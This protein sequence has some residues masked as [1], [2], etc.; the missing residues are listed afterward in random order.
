MRDVRERSPRGDV[1]ASL[2]FV[3]SVYS[4]LVGNSTVR[5]EWEYDILISEMSLN[6]N[7][8]HHIEYEEKETL[9]TW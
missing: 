2:E 7:L 3:F 9:H 5:M 6:S 4:K 8:G 1:M